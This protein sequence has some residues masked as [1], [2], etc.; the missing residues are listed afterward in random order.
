M[1]TAFL[2]SLFSFILL[3]IPIAFSLILTT[4]V[5]MVMSGE[6]SSANIASSIYRGVDN[7]PLMVKIPACLS[8][9]GNILL[10]FT[11]IKVNR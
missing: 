10:P 5:L 7:F 11:I 6:L 4:I 9:G 2:S 3:N 8:Q 1:L